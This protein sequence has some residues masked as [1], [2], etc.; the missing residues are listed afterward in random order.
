MRALPPPW[1]RFRRV[2]D[3]AALARMLTLPNFLTLLRIVAVPA[4]LILLTNGQFGAALILF[5]AA[6]ITD[7]V[8]GALARI[9]HS[10]S[11]LG[12]SLD[13]LA[14]KLLVVSSFLML[15][16]LGVIP[17]WL[18]ILVATRDVVILGGYLALYFLSTPMEVAPSLVSKINTFNG[19][20]TIGF[21]LLTLARP[22]V[23]MAM[24]NLVTW[25]A[26][27]ATTT[28][29][30]LHYVYSGLLWFQRQGSGGTEQPR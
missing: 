25:Y 30:G 7:A 9:M 1:L 29:S 14:D 20:F 15:T 19:M 21:A 17:T 6:G 13:P 10:K 11:D 5:F 22:D 4:F 16:W 27:G 18:F 24:V 12:A 2:G 8:D 28:L 26:T 23:P 3:R